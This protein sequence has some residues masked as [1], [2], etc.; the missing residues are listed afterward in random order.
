MIPAAVVEQAEA[1]RKSGVTNMTT[2]NGVQIAANDAGFY[3]LVLWIEDNSSDY[4]SLLMEL[5]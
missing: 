4:G 1:V 2:R 5:G 3:A